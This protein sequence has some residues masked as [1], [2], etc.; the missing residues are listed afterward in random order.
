M[1]A[2]FDTLAHIVGE[3][4]V[5]PEGQ[6]IGK[7]MHIAYEPNTLRPEWLVLKTSRFGRPR[8]VPVDAAD[9]RGDTVHVPFPKDMVLGSP[10]PEIPTT[11]ATTEVTALEAHYRKAA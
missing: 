11:P 1:D 9:A 5:D 4:V 6:R 2:D 10:V 8:L 7:V 3:P